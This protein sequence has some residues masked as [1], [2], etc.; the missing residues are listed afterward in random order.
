MMIPPP[1]H[2][3]T[4]FD[5]WNEFYESAPSGVDVTISTY[6]HYVLVENPDA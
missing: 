2:A 5:D 4:Y 1:L 3:W 6:Y